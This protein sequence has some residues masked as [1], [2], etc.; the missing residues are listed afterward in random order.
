MVTRQHLVWSGDDD[1]LGG[2]RLVGKLV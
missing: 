1:I 2:K